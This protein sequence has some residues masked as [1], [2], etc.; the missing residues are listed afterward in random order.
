[1]TD[2][3]A[4]ENDLSAFPGP[5]LS[6]LQQRGYD[7]VV[8]LSNFP[9][10]KNDRFVSWIREHSSVEVVTREVSL[11]SPTN[12]EQIYR[13]AVEVID[14]LLENRQVDLTF[15][16]SPGTPAMAAV[17]IILAKTKYSAELIESSVAAGVQTV[18][19]PFQMSAEFLPDVELERFS[20]GRAPVNSGFEDIVFRSEVME[21]LVDLARR[22][23]P[24]RI[25]I[26]IEGESGT[27][28]ELLARAI[29]R[30]SPRAKG[31]FIAVNC[32]AIPLELV[33][34]EL[35]GHEKG[36]FTGASQKRDGHFISANGGTI[37][38]DEVAELPRGIQVK[39]LRVLQESE[40]T[41]LGSS[42]PRRLDV[43]V[44]SATNR[45][46]IEETAHGRF[47][48]DLFYR[49]AVAILQ[50]PPLRERGADIGLLIDHILTRLNRESEQ[51][52]LGRKSLTPGA[53]NLLLGHD[54]PGNIRELQNTLLRA[55]VLAHQERIGEKEVR[56]AILRPS[57]KRD[58]GVLNRRLGNGFNLPEV[59]GEVARHYLERALTEAPGNRSDAAGLVGLPSYQTLN[60]WLKRYGVEGDAA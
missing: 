51:L 41:P 40:V 55:S 39:L 58:D 54:W 37:F 30:A 7:E 36:A 42:R 21:R 6:A 2:L 10:T 25:P 34:A 35:F 32:G 4:A 31:P 33:E 5:I 48:E 22:V 3:R 28:K 44:I 17:W 43:R 29:H 56:E 57:G 60:N 27:G 46:L 23:A 14:G 12:F 38:L 53:R 59:L 1:M 26:L 8:L 18:S 47:R 50:L 49:L 11:T 15:H 16:L 19:I 52:D 20:I 13:R 9:S 45:P 24:R